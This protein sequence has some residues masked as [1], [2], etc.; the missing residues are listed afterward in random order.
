[1]KVCY[2][3]C[4]LSGPGN[5]HMKFYMFSQ[6]GSADNVIMVGSNNMTYYAANTHWND[7]FTV[8]GRPAMFESYSTVF[9]QLAED[10]KVPSPTWCSATAT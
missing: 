3:S 4:R 9:R 6:A 2:R 7:M 8:I 1:M 10:K 5:Q